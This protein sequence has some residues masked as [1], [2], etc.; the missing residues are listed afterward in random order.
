LTRLARKR[1]GPRLLG[2]FGNGRFEEFLHAEPL[3][4]SVQIAKRMRELHEGIDLLKKEREAG[5]FV[6]QNWD[7]WVSRCEYIVTWLDQ[8]VRESNQGIS[9][10]SSDKWKKRGYVCGTEWP[11][12]KQTIYK[13][14]KWLEDQY[15]GI[16]KI[17][18]RMV[19]AHNDVSCNVQ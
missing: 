4:S 6:W 9:R 5:P 11:M 17:N 8:Q 16:D 18:E 7:K 14:R 15:G 12:F 1:I 3:T 10:A 13:Y 19:F 2:T